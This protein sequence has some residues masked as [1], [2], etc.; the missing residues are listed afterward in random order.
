MAT[1]T[2]KKLLT[3]KKSVIPTGAKRSKRSG[4]TWFFRRAQR[5]AGQLIHSADFYSCDATFCVN[6]SERQQTALPSCTISR[7]PQL[8]LL[9]FAPVGMIELCIGFLIQGTT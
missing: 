8:R 9:R 2:M 7:S 4:G 1:R 6:V 3:K 5:L